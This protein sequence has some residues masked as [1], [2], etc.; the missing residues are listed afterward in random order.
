MMVEVFIFPS[1]Q[2]TVAKTVGSRASG[3]NSFNSC[4]PLC[5]LLSH[6]VLLSP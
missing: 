6:S 2:S 1:S 5:Q 3:S 4:V